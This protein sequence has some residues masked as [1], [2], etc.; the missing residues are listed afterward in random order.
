MMIHWATAK[1]A[2][3]L[4]GLMFATIAASEKFVGFLAETINRDTPVSLEAAC[5][6]GAS[7]LTFAIWINRK[8]VGIEH[9]INDLKDHAGLGRRKSGRKKD[10]QNSA[11]Q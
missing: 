3:L 7:I 11:D 1:G 2:A 5:I 4:S 9:D 6:V 8:F 10:D